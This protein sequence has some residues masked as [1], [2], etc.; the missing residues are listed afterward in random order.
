MEPLAEYPL[1]SK[2]RDNT[3]IFLD[4][5]ASRL[6]AVILSHSLQ[7]LGG[8]YLVFDVDT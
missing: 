1:L 4:N 8:R 2:T 3:V 7:S 5:R 6:A